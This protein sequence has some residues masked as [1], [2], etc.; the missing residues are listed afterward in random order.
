TGKVR[1]FDEVFG[2]EAHRNFWLTLDDLAH[3]LCALL[4]I[5]EGPGLV[6]SPGDRGKEHTVF[7]AVT[8][9]DLTDERE[10]IKRDLQQHGSTVLPA[11]AS[12][13]IGA[14][15]ETAVREDL[16]RCSMSIHLVGKLYS[17]IPEGRVASVVEIHNELAIERGEQGAFTRLLWIPKGLQI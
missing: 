9:G 7:L 4:E 2:P 1:E 3:D 6:S 12:S 10:A 11:R 14:E 16:A 17:L 5:V 13:L 15:I 8:T